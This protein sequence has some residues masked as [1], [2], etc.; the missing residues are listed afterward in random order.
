MLITTLAHLPPRSILIISQMK[1]YYWQA[2]FYPSHPIA[3]AES[4]TNGVMVGSN[5]GVEGQ[6]AYC[7]PFWVHKT[8]KDNTAVGLS[9]VTLFRSREVPEPM[10]GCRASAAVPGFSWIST[11]EGFS[12]KGTPIS[13]GV[14]WGNLSEK[15]LM[16]NPS[17][18]VSSCSF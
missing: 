14:R 6:D 10:S 13:D 17:Q 3:L 5:R 2:I 7:S 15:I 9:G 1:Y 18:N 11:V 16:E 8:D 12:L 4:H